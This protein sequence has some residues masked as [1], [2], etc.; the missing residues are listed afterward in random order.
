MNPAKNYDHLFSPLGD[1]E[2]PDDVLAHPL[3]QA[4]QVQPQGR[5][6]PVRDGQGDGRR[7]R[8]AQGQGQPGIDSKRIRCAGCSHEI[9]LVPSLLVLAGTRGPG[10]GD[11]AQAGAVEYGAGTVMY[12]KSERGRVTYCASLSARYSKKNSTQMLFWP[13]CRRP[14]RRAAIGRLLRVP[15][16]PTSRAVP[17]RTTIDLHP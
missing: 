3:A 7:A 17:I 4:H 11:L 1:P 10:P 15:E 13:L 14:E 6:R 12:K 8:G 9:S 5:D 16:P 2:A